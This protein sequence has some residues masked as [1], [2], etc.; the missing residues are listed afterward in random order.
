MKLDNAGNL[1]VKGNVDVKGNLYVKGSVGIGT[2]SPAAKLDVNGDLI[3]RGFTTTLKGADL[4]IEYAPRGSGGRAL[5]H[6]TGNVLAI[7]FA[8]DFTGGTRIDGNLTVG[9]I[10]LI[11]Y[12]RTTDTIGAN[13]GKDVSCPAGKRVLSCSIDT[14]NGYCVPNTD[15]SC[16]CHNYGVLASR[17]A[18]LICAK[19]GN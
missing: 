2:T 8:G 13:S 16:Y 4:R 17:T 6:D 3:V 5:V 9:G 18:Y 11:G 14:Y 12:E 19:I 1:W 10:A 15:T 7:N